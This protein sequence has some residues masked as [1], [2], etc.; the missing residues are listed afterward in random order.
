MKVLQLPPPSPRERRSAKKVLLLPPLLS[1][2]VLLLPPVALGSR[3]E[4]RQQALMIALQNTVSAT[5]RCEPPNDAAS[6]PRPFAP[7]LRNAQRRWPER[8][9]RA[10]LL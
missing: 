8:S 4:E 9:W 10:A 6:A 5:C 7:L 1:W 3:K 2:E